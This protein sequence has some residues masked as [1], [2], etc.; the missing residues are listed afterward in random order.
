MVAEH[1]FAAARDVL[2][3]RRGAQ[4][5]IYD[6]S[7]PAL[8]SG[9]AIARCRRRTRFRQIFQFDPFIHLDS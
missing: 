5:S 7:P 4:V 9:R 8:R 2:A 1:S 3:Q 6:P